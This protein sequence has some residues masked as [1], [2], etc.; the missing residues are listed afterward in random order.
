[1]RDFYF[2]NGYIMV[3]THNHDNWKVNLGPNLINNLHLKFKRKCTN[4]P[5][6]LICNCSWILLCR[7]NFP[8]GMMAIW[9]ESKSAITQLTRTSLLLKAKSMPTVLLEKIT[10]LINGPPRLQVKVTAAS[11]NKTMTQIIDAT[12]N[13]YPPHRWERFFLL[14][15]L[16]R[17][18]YFIVP[19]QLWGGAGGEGKMVGKRGFTYDHF[20]SFGPRDSRL[21]KYQ[22]FHVN[23][24]IQRCT[25][26]EEPKKGL[27]DHLTWMEACSQ[28][29]RWDTIH[30]K[31]RS[32]V[33]SGRKQATTL[34]D[35]TVALHLS[36]QRYWE[37]QR[38]FKRYLD[39]SRHLLELGHLTHLVLRP[40]EYVSLTKRYLL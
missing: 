20:G 8:F 23:C 5:F 22:S 40:I 6:E 14:P 30:A 10:E 25:T 33:T 37:M 2:H 17:T 18:H 34:G 15:F 13:T 26:Q 7:F 3:I 29:P 24:S 1:M 11:C 32:S 39:R 28:V 21:D 38:T 12:I 36:V 4:L 16:S 27:W 19:F 35:R 31:S 9:V